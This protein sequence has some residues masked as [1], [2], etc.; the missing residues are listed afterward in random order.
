MQSSFKR[1]QY[2]PCKGLADREDI[3]WMSLWS[4]IKDFT[5]EGDET[6]KSI[7]TDI[8]EQ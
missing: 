3:S 2:W 7:D 4:Q 6:W 5:E 1:E 8:E